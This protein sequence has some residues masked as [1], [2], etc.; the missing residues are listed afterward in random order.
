MTVSVYQWARPTAS[1]GFNRQQHRC[2][3]LKFRIRTPCNLY[4]HVDMEDCLCN[5]IILNKQTTCSAVLLVSMCHT[6]AC[7]NKI[8]V[9]WMYEMTASISDGTELP[10]HAALYITYSII[11]CTAGL[12]E[13][14]TY[15]NNYSYRN[16]SQNVARFLFGKET[17]IE[18]IPFIL[19]SIIFINKSCMIYTSHQMLFGLWSEEKQDGRDM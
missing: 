7:V 13:T 4:I 17:Q 3:N 15:L 1:R 5:V 2:E 10:K 8:S 6:H 18:C 11:C 16:G 9:F 14:F 19:L 12:Y